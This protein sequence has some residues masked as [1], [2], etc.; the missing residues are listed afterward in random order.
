M[1]KISTLSYALFFALLSVP[2]A[3]AVTLGGLELGDQKI[4]VK[5]DIDDPR[6]AVSSNGFVYVVGNDGGQGA[7]QVIDLT[8]GTISS[9]ETFIS[10]QSALNGALGGGSAS[11]L[12]GASKLTDGTVVYHGS[13]ATSANN[14]NPT[15]WL[16]PTHPFAA[17]NFST[18]SGI[19]NFVSPSGVTGGYLNNPAA[20]GTLNTPFANL[21][22]ATIGTTVL[23]ISAD[24]RFLVGTGIWERQNAD[25]LDYALLDTSLWLSP[26]D[27]LGTPTTFDAV[28]SVGDDYIF[29]GEYIDA[30]LFTSRVGLWDQSGNFLGGTSAGDR[31][32][33]I[34]LFDGEVVIGVNGDLGGALY[35]L[36]DLST[37]L[38]LSDLYGAP[39]TLVSDSFFVGSL[40]MI[41]QGANGG[42]FAASFEI[43][44]SNAV[45]EPGSALLLLLGV[46]AAAKRR[47]NRTNR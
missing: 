11:F 27:G 29:V 44:N 46:S 18:D 10:Q 17:S 40:G 26:S 19:V 5:I 39:T 37:A 12:F 7:R 34:G 23:D 47:R 15:Y 20:V 16:D 25:S 32:A 1:R 45:P 21:P 28:L 22:G 9:I 8:T 30:N 36:S 31:F 41:A 42:L 33:D 13:S 6:A 24:D 38:L 43:G 35:A 2:A 4:D 14:G 3:N